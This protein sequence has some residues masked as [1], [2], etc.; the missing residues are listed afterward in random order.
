MSSALTLLLALGLKAVSSE[1]SA[2]IRAMYW[3]LTPPT[4]RKAPPITILPS[5]CRAIALIVL[6]TTGLKL[7]SSD[8]SAFSRTMLP[9]V[10]PE[11][12][13]R[14]PASSTLPSSCTAS[15]LIWPLIWALGRKD[16]RRVPS[17]LSQAKL[18]S[19]VPMAPPIIRAATVFTGPLA[20]G[21]KEESG[22]LSVV[23]RARLL[24]EVPPKV[25]KEPPSRTRPSACTVSELITEPVGPPA[26]G[27]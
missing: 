16:V 14:L 4:L 22:T 13:R 3:R 8:P 10:A 21:L 23:N 20:S 2:L 15:A 7:A 9:L 5:D 17:L 1:P 25:A 27:V 12:S 19:W 6:S 18:P 11:R 24:L 26:L